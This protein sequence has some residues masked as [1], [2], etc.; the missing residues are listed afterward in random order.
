MAE[1]VAVHGVVEGVEIKPKERFVVKVR[2]KPD[3]EYAVNLNTKDTEVASQ[4]MGAVGQSFSFKCSISEWEYQGKPVKSKWIQE[5]GV[6][7]TVFD[8][9]QPD[10]PPATAQQLSGQEAHSPGADRPAAQPPTNKDAS[11][12]FQSMAKGLAVECFKRLPTEEQTLENAIKIADRWALEALKRGREGFATSVVPALAP[13]AVY[14]PQS[15]AAS[16]EPPH[17]DDDIPF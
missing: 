12:A 5:I 4:M 6:Y 16:N 10:L 17:P 11:I 1:E 3:D 15:I 14:E 9:A 7:G 8:L 2:Q 13:A